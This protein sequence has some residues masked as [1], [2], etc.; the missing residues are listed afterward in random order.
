[1]ITSGFPRLS[2]TFA[3][4][5]FLALER[6]GRIEAI[7]ATKP[8]DGRPGHPGIEA[9]LARVQRL[10]AGSPAAQ[11]D[12]LAA[13]VRASRP[14]GIHAYFAHTPAEVAAHAAE[15]LG[16]P[17]SFTVHARDARK[18]SREALRD[19]AARA[20]GVIACN[21]DVARELR[22]V[23]AN[24]ELV[25][26][27]VDLDRFSPGPLPPA[28]PLRLLA[29]GRLV[30]KKGFAVLLDALARLNAPV[31]LRIVGDGPLRA[32]LERSIAARAL[33]DRVVLT[34]PVTHH[35]LPGAY[36]DAHAVIVPSVQDTTGDRDGL[37]N[38]VLEAMASGRP[39]VASDIAAIP[40]A[41]RDGYTGVLVPPA[42]P[43]ALARALE[44]LA[45]DA[46][47]RAR[48]GAAARTLVERE[49]ELRKC[50][51]RLLDCLEAAYA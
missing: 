17:Y 2:E 41:V 5:E 22:T 34:G 50:T 49:F 36:A 27:G 12:W 19:R 10:P 46:P 23:G 33:G 44:Q 48:M 4:N 43:T 20:A 47:L 9:L 6:A 31:H 13:R 39:V 40:S 32:Q 3:L 21:D 14:T 37:P 30:E 18:V 11:A 51:G 8:G 25:P 16:V 7:F 42:D 45:L 38:V 28:Q 15:A 26:H 35:A 1:M 24:V 29:V